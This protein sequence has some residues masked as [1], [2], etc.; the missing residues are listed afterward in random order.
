M[1]LFLSFILQEKQINQWLK[2]LN[3]YKLLDYKSSKKEILFI[4]KS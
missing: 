1:H 3:V 4:Y 2:Y